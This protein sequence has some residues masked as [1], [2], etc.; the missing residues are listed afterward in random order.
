[1]G[2]E[3][4]LIGNYRQTILL[5]L[6]VTLILENLVLIR[7]MSNRIRTLIYF[8]WLW[9]LCDTFPI[10]PCKNGRKKRKRRAPHHVVIQNK[11]FQI[12][13]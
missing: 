3:D 7:E 11:A 8:V 6:F 1:M 13:L 4:G 5:P 9:L 12:K 10:I 2:R